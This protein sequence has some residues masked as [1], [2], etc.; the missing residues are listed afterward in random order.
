MAGARRLPGFG[1]CLCE[2]V[3]DTGQAAATGKADKP[4]Q[5]K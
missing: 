1:H 5:P 2:A 4:D 3:R